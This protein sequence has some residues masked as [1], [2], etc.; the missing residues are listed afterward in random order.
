MLTPLFCF[1]VSI[2]FSE[3]FAQDIVV[4]ESC[5]NFD[6]FDL[7]IAGALVGKKTKEFKSRFSDKDFEDI[8]K[9]KF[10]SSSIMM[11]YS[12]VDT[13]ISLNPLKVRR[14][15]SNFSGKVSITEESISCKSFASMIRKIRDYYESTGEFPFMAIE[16]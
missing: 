9:I 14:R 4:S 12:Y 8:Q 15:Q 3:I 1:L 2:N 5:K 13:V 10:K 16:Y 6:K 7:A 11:D